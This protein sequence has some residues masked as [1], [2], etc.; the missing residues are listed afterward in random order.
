ME[1]SGMKWSEAGRL[2]EQNK[3][4]WCE[5]S[6]R[7]SHAHSA[8][9]RTKKTERNKCKNRD[10]PINTPQFS[11]LKTVQT[12]IFPTKLSFTDYSFASVQSKTNCPVNSHKKT[13]NFTVLNRPLNPAL[14]VFTVSVAF[15]L[16]SYSV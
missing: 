13:G 1:R 15:L 16:I 12:L 2:L 10:S 6:L 9:K 5:W 11:I 3:A 4:W 14:T 7:N 8:E